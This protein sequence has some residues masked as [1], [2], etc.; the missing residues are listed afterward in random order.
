MYDINDV[1]KLAEKMMKGQDI[2]IDDHFDEPEYI[3]PKVILDSN[4]FPVP[5]EVPS[6]DDEED[7]I[8]SLKW[9]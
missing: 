2:S 7:H 5:I 9:C 8:H 1:H 3:V 4:D 6:S